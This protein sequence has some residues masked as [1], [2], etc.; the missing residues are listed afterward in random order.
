MNPAIRADL[1]MLVPELILAGMALV[2]VLAARRIQSAP[3][4]PLALVGTVLAA[5]AAALEIGRAHV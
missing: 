5:V 3:R 1:V 4:A 2:L